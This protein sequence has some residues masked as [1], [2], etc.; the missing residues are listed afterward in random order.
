M[1]PI[2]SV[3]FVLVLIAFLLGQVGCSGARP[4]A[5]AQ[6]TAASTQ[7]A[8]APTPQPLPTPTNTINVSQTSCLGKGLIEYSLW[9]PDGK[10]FAVGTSIGVYLYDGATFQELR[11]LDTGSFADGMAFSPDNQL[12]AVG[13]TYEVLTTS[14]VQV[15]NVNTGQLLQTNQISGWPLRALAFAPDGRLLVATIYSSGN[16]KEMVVS[17]GKTGQKLYSL[18]KE[19]SIVFNA[20]GSLIVEAAEKQI[21]I[22][23]T[24]TGLLEYILPIW[25]SVEMSMLSPD[26]R[27]LAFIDISQSF[28]KADT[29]KLVNVQTGEI[30]NTLS[31]KPDTAVAV[32]FDA[33]GNPLG[34]S[35]SAGSTR[36]WNIKSGQ[37][38]QTFT[39]SVVYMQRFP[40]SGVLL[41][42]DG[43][44]LVIEGYRELSFWNVETGNKI[45]EQTGFTNQIYALA[46]SPD[47]QKL[48]WGGS[49]AYFKIMDLNTNNILYTLNFDDA[50]QDDS[51]HINGIAFSPDGQHLAITGFDTFGYILDAQT[52]Q[53][54]F[55]LPGK[56]RRVVYSSD[57]QTFAVVTDEQVQ[58]W[59]AADNQLLYTLN[60]TQAYVF[61]IAISPD[62][63][64]LATSRRDEKIKLWEAKTGQFIRELSENSAK[65]AFHPNGHILAI[66]TDGA[67]KLIDIETGQQVWQSPT[68]YSDQIIFSADGQKMFSK[69]DADGFLR[70]WDA[71]NGQLL[72]SF[73]SNTQTHS[74]GTFAVSSNGHLLATGG[75]SGQLCLWDIP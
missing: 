73:R 33:Q 9:S 15:W 69:S 46:F 24:S 68:Q 67:I 52:G 44:T 21:F 60:D 66:F 63:R 17:D 49:Y 45:T 3:S 62:G 75:N 25:L 58:L 10:I 35:T 23:Q 12:L 47:G 6:P 16:A 20:D 2:R 19:G 32:A 56:V 48:A 61:A 42:P 7:T 30:M 59:N 65:I 36:L 18:N 55:N 70:I 5:Q 40:I 37:V 72:S 38:L 31:V 53:M 34:V 22:W 13:G 41:S 29:F 71:S 1:K 27:S 11:F 57:G 54:L 28:E 50:K 64:Y 74:S 26:N 39:S 4:P 8:A 51:K 14:Q 43:H